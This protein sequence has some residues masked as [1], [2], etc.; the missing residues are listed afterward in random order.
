MPTDC[1]LEKIPLDNVWIFVD[2][3]KS[4]NAWDATL[5]RFR[6]NLVEC[7]RRKLYVAF[8]RAKEFRL[9]LDRAI[10]DMAR[11]LEPGRTDLGSGRL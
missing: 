5:M 10:Q 4:I 11:V 3:G 1:D 6:A 7:E 2:G 8:E 9:Q